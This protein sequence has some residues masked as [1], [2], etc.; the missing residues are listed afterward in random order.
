MLQ[1]AEA[2]VAEA[3]VVRK[4][5]AAG[6][7]VRLLHPQRWSDAVARLLAPLEQ[8]LQ[9][10]LGCNAYLTPPDS[11]VRPPSP[12][13]CVPARATCVGLAVHEHRMCAPLTTC[14]GLFIRACTGC[15]VR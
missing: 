12:L 6:A 8:L 7:S 13:A 2:E 11:Q 9:C 1:G 3:A 4:R 10:P 5:F 15:H 14:G